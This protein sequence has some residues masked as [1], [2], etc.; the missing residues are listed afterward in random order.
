MI[1]LLTLPQTANLLPKYLLWAGTM[2]SRISRSAAPCL[3]L[4]V[5]LGVY[6]LGFVSAQT[7]EFPLDRVEPWT[8]APRYDVPQV[9]T[10][11]QLAEILDRLKP[12]IDPL[13]TNN[14][15][16]ALRLWGA[17]ARF[18]EPDLPS[19]EAMRQYILDDAQFIRMAGDDAAPLVSIT[20]EGIE[21]REWVIN[22]PH[23]ATSSYHT[24]DLLATLAETGTRL[25][26]PLITRNG[27]TTVAALLETS[28]RQYHD[29]Q[30]E[31]EWTA[32]SYARY[33]MPLTRWKNKFGESIHVRDLIDQ[34]IN[35]PWQL[36]PCNGTH[37]LEA[38][39][40]LLRADD[41][42]Q[43][44]SV[45]SRHRVLKHLVAVSALL[46]RAQTQD[47]YWTRRWPLG[48]SASTDTSAT[49]ADRVLV[50]GH[51]LEWLALAPPE[52]QPPRE[53]VVRAAQW[54]VR[55][56]LEVDDKTLD[57]SYTFY[58]HAA[59]ALCLWRK[60]DPFLIWKH[61]MYTATEAE[62]ATPPAK[63][64]ES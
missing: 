57:E 45:R 33:L 11:E 56:M 47:G 2:L 29:Q 3:L 8:I 64:L 42:A 30:L 27:S 7:Q 51:H 9:A 16:H 6:R 28:M 26:T 14:I 55:T 1:L 60:K 58:T 49:M 10:D 5:A 22:E 12:P 37:R 39:S 36:G 48:A 52:V 20:P 13:D 38:M 46:T 31:Y 21:V 44:L 15:V 18:D 4:L 32:I 34:L 23:T 43:S 35:H 62:T 19:G 63:N 17:D 61:G 40:V 25:D 59:R 53:T 41:Q 24:N 54:L 50:T